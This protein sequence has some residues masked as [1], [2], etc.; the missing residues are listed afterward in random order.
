MIAE[1]NKQGF[2]NGPLA[3]SAIAEEYEE[4]ED[5]LFNAKEPNLG[6]LHESP[7]HRIV[8]SLRAQGHSQRKIAKLIGFTEAWVSQILRQPWAKVQLL[9][10]LRKNGG[11]TMSTLLEAEA[12]DSLFKIVQVRDTA[13]D[14][15]VQ[16]R[17]A[18]DLLD[19]HL[20]KAIARIESKSEA[21]ITVE[22]ASALERAIDETEREINRI[23]GASPACVPQANV[24]ETREESSDSFAG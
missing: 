11:D 19:R 20:G 4:R 13:L 6:I 18:Q 14:P 1:G 15:A 24:G 2:Q 17:A 16:L 8:I 22:D 9:E 21:H 5:V 10:E 3:G 23:R 12:E 7:K